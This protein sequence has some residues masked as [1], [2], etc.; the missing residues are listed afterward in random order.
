MVGVEAILVS[1]FLLKGELSRRH[2]AVYSHRISQLWGTFF[3]DCSKQ[4]FST[5][6][7]VLDV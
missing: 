7:E 6:T 5:R 3:A 1:V 4:R 2:C